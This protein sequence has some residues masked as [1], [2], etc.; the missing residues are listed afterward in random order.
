MSDQNQLGNYGNVFFF[1]HYT[2]SVREKG[3]KKFKY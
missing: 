1:M 2:G 3:N